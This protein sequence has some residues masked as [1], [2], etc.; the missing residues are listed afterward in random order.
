[1][2]DKTSDLIARL[3]LIIVGFA[4]IFFSVK[5]GVHAN[6][7]YFDGLVAMSN[8][9]LTTSLLL[10]LFCFVLLCAGLIGDN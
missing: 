1:M 4:G 8:I 7:I 2:K 5:I 10:F 3:I 6:K 9:A